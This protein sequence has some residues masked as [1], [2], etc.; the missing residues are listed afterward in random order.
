MTVA[1]KLDQL[2]AQ[3]LGKPVEREDPSNLDQ[4]FD[5]AFAYVDALG[6]PRS[7]IRH[8]LASQI[9][10][11][12]TVLTKQYFELI[13]NTPDFVPQKGDMPVFGTEIGKAG[14]V[15]LAT[16]L[17]D[18]NKFQSADENWNGHLYV[19]YVW[20]TYGGNQGLLG[21]LRPKNQ[22]GG[23]VTNMYGGLDLNN[24]DSMKPCVDLFNKWRNG[25]LVEKS[26][27]DQ[28]NSQIAELSKRPAS[29]PPAGDP[30]T[31]DKLNRIAAMVASDPIVKIN[32]IL[33]A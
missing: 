11:D 22:G 23:T 1:E 18:T 32:D 21:V 29:C 12:A 8:L 6:I 24:P 27:L 33:K 28:A 2:I 9:W 3:N 15:C 30:A 10:T 25:G 17:G 31:T 7:A 19:E 5:W 4:C 14:H 13:P 16:G 20:H 26:S